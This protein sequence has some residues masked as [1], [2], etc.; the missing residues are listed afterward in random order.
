LVLFLKRYI[1]EN[2]IQ[3]EREKK[4]D[5]QLTQ[6]L[7]CNSRME[8]LQLRNAVKK[9]ACMLQTTEDTCAEEAFCDGDKLTGLHELPRNIHRGSAWST[10]L[11]T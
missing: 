4:M 8:E 11:L 1:I 5:A 10:D 9:M 2:I 6:I 3:K 7:V